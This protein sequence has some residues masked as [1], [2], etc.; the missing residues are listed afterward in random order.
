MQNKVMERKFAEGTCL[1]VRTV[2]TY[3]SDGLFELP[4]YVDGADYADARDE[5]WIW[6]IG[7]SD[8]DGRI[9]AATDDRFYLCPGWECIF[10][11]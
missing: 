4:T 6:S 9:F 10:L 3:V 1:D 2:G 11:R 8:M 7:K 5:R